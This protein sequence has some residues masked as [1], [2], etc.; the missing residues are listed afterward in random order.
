MEQLEEELQELKIEVQVQKEK[1][2]TG[3]NE[4]CFQ[5]SDADES[6]LRKELAERDNRIMEL[7]IKW[8]LY[9]S[10]LEC[11]I[12]TNRLGRAA[13]PRRDSTLVTVDQQVN[14]RLKSLTPYQ[15]SLLLIL[16]PYDF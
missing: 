13:S 7:Q 1:D 6:S 12:A 5:T 4:G 14:N 3:D 10:E 16:V 15:Q 2:I 8:N 9:K 11:H